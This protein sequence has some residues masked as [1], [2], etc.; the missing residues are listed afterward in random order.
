VSTSPT[1]VFFV[2]RSLTPT[3]IL[4]VR[5][6]PASDLVRD[7]YTAN[8]MYEL[9]EQLCGL[10]PTRDNANI[11]PLVITGLSSCVNV[12]SLVETTPICNGFMFGKW[13]LGKKKHRPSICDF[14]RVFSLLKHQKWR[15]AGFLRE[16]LV[17][18]WQASF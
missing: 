18:T 16:L 15:P 3:P 7:P 14:P 5:Y 17:G 2:P 9:S 1:S 8:E 11:Y 4:V 6:G 13:T 12:S 10:R